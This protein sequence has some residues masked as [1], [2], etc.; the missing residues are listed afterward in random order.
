[1]VEGFQ[2]HLMAVG[3]GEFFAGEA[4]SIL[5][6]GWVLGAVRSVREVCPNCVDK[7]MILSRGEAVLLAVE[8]G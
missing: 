6:D 5:R 7:W 4:H 2:V 1:M 3:C 8:R